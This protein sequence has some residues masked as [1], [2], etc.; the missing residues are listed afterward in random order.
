MENYSVNWKTNTENENSS[1]RKTREDIDW[2]F[3]QIVLFMAR[4]NQRLL[5]I[6]NLVIFQMIGLKWIKSLTHFYLLETNLF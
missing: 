1:F 2:C 4:K 6:K 3:Y 5:K